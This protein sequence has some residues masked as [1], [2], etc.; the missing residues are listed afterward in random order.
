MYA[1]T[2]SRLIFRVF[3]RERDTLWRTKLAAFRRWAKLVDQ[4]RSI[5]K[6]RWCCLAL[7]IFSSFQVMVLHTEWICRRILEQEGF[8]CVVFTLSWRYENLNFLC[9]EDKSTMKLIRHKLT[10]SRNVWNA[11]AFRSMAKRKTFFRIKAAMIVVGHVILWSWR[12]FIVVRPLTD[13]CPWPKSRSPR[14]VLPSTNFSHVIFAGAWPSTDVRSSTKS[15][16]A[17]K[18]ETF[19]VW[20]ECVAMIC[21]IFQWWGNIFVFLDSS[22]KLVAET[23]CWT[24]VHFVVY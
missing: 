24:T 21:V 13:A 10:R 18:G 17:S 8:R 16:R 14:F 2:W 19:A 7:L 5:V 6:W 11:S 22:T 20:T 1:L 9:D 3:L 15:R 4:L 23:V 12:E